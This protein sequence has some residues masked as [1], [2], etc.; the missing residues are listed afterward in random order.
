MDDKTLELIS[1]GVI[2]A[3][4]AVAYFFVLD[5]DAKDAF[6]VQEEDSGIYFDSKIKKIDYDADSDTTILTLEATRTIRAYHQG[7][8]ERQVGDRIFVEGSMYNG[9]INVNSVK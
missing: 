3:G 7:M 6:F 1:L 4:L 8:L 5:N 9:Y 2:I